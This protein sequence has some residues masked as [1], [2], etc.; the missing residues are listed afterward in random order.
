MLESLNTNL[1]S[2]GIL[3]I[4]CLAEIML[5]K[6]EHREFGKKLLNTLTKIM[7]DSEITENKSKLHILYAAYFI[8]T[9][10]V[11]QKPKIF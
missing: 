5:S 2:P 1:R 7:K 10:K 3:T 11:N 6:K 9:K 8:D 4:T